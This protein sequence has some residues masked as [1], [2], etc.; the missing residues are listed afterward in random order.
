MKKS[1]HIPSTPTDVLLTIIDR[2]DY[3]EDKYEL[4]RW[5]ASQRLRRLRAWLDSTQGHL[6]IELTEMVKGPKERID[7]GHGLRV[8]TWQSCDLARACHRIHAIDL[9]CS[10]M[11]WRWLVAQ[12]IRSCRRH[13]RMM[14]AK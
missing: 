11:G 3:P 1:R 14:E 9:K 7:F 5:L 10:R 2:W 4:D 13:I 6:T 12:A 8:L